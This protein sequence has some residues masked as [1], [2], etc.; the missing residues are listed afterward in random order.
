MSE[1]TDNLIVGAKV[2]SVYTSY[3][4]KGY[5]TVTLEL[6]DG[7][8]IELDAASDGYGASWIEAR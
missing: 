2:V 6:P 7:S 5:I 8:T 1:T 4:E 3:G